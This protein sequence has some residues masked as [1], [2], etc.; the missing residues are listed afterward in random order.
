MKLYLF[1]AGRANSVLSLKNY[2]G[3]DCEIERLRFKRGEQLKPEYARLNPNK[4][5]PTLEDDGFVLWE[6]NAILF[7]IA[8]K[9]PDKGLWPSD[10]KGQADCMRWLAW[11]G[12]HWDAESCGMVAFE[13]GSK[14]VMSLGPADPAFEKRGEENW[15]RFAGV[16]D[17]YLK[18]KKWLVSDKLTIA[19]FSIGGMIPNALAV[20][21]SIDQFPEISRW[22]SH[23]AALPGWHSDLST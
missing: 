10:L 9:Y 5:M 23:L 12:A 11:E 19:D 7:Y 15:A 2:L 3:L 18:G 1:P 4:K 13:R 8:G 16:L 20:G 17:G 14:V 6:S 21:L 22:Y